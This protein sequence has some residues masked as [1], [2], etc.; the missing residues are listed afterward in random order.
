MTDRKTKQRLAYIIIGMLLICV[1]LAIWG[2]V[3]NSS[4]TA[5]A[6]VQENIEVSQTDLEMNALS[7]DFETLAL[8]GHT[9]LAYPICTHDGGYKIPTGNVALTQGE[10]GVYVNSYNN[11]EL[12]YYF[13]DDPAYANYM[14]TAIPKKCYYATDRYKYQYENNEMLL[15]YDVVDTKVYFTFKSNIHP[16]ISR[17]VFAPKIL[18]K[19]Y[20]HIWSMSLSFLSRFDRLRQ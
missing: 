14:Y 18:P 6:D 13:R 10:N 8:S 19:A 9:T 17:L 4:L 7:M 20:S 2:N 15:D 16:R 12:T 1:L 11:S 5:S 3:L